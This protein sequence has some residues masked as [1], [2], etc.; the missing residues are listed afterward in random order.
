MKIVNN[1]KMQTQYSSSL[2][3]SQTEGGRNRS[4]IQYIYYLYYLVKYRISSGLELFKNTSKITKCKWCGSTDM[5]ENRVCDRC[6]WE[7]G[8]L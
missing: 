5:V 1:A 3:P 8:S 6:H 7:G 2:S 4:I